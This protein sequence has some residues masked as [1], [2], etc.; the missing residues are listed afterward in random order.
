MEVQ[1]SAEGEGL[2]PCPVFSGSMTE[3]DNKR[4]KFTFAGF[5][6]KLINIQI[7]SIRSSVVKECLFCFI[8]QSSLSE[9]SWSWSSVLLHRAATALN[10]LLDQ[11]PELLH[12]CSDGL[13]LL[14][15]EVLVGLE[16]LRGPWLLI[17]EVLVGL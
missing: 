8:L 9:L 16:S 3:Q 17:L 12:L 13:Q 5:L 11:S 6:Y 7:T 1:V 14:I 15:Q 4:S 2:I 10:Q